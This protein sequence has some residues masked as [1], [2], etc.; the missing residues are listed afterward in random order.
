MSFRPVV[1][2]LSG[3]VDWP[4]GG[5]EMVLC[6]QRASA[7]TQ[8]H[9][10]AQ[11]A[12]AHVCCFTHPYTSARRSCKWSCAQGRL[13]LTRPSSKGAAA[14]HQTGAPGLGGQ[15]K[16]KFQPEGLC[17]HGDAEGVPMQG[18]IPDQSLTPSLWA[19]GADCRALLQLW[20]GGIN[21]TRAR[22]FF[23]VPLRSPPL[24]GHS[25]SQSTLD[26]KFTGADHSLLIRT[27][28]SP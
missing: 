9:L 3:F 24:L 7:W 11:R 6:K 13:L 12:L 22:D 28:H 21:S 27:L 23:L 18:A 20:G 16:A 25:W 14:Q 15:D 1:P 17:R 5:E 10:R 2:S 8:L 26:S 19:L 4:G